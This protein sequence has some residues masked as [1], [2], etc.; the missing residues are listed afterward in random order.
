MARF[1]QNNLLTVQYKYS[2]SVPEH[3]MLK[4]PILRTRWF[5]TG[6]ITNHGWVVHFRLTKMVRRKWFVPVRYQLPKGKSVG[7]DIKKTLFLNYGMIHRVGRVNRAL[8]HVHMALLFMNRSL[9]CV[10]RCF[11]CVNRSNILAWFIGGQATTLSLRPCLHTLHRRVYENE[12][13]VCMYI[14]LSRCV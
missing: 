7:Q 6:F 13:S 14:M 10:N 9:L 5:S 2:K 3:Q 8:L 11:L 4:D 1:Q 12:L